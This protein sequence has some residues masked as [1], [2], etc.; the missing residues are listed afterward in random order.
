MYFVVAYISD[1]FQRRA[2]CV[3]FGGIAAIIGNILMISG[4]SVAVQYFGCFVIVTGVYIV[5]NL[6]L[7]WLTT[8]L[9]RFSKRTTAVGTFLMCGS[10]A[11]VA[12]PFVRL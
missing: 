6:A 3:I 9:P 11:G 5:G 4:R 10:G 7:V 8:N 1:K 2:P 12:A